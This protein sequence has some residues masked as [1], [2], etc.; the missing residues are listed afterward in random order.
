MQLYDKNRKLTFQVNV[1]KAM[2]SGGEG[3]ICEHPVNKSLVVKVYH[4]DRDLKLEQALLELSVLGPEFVKPEDICYTLNGRIAG[5]TMRFVDLNKYVILKKL[6]NKNTAA[7]L[8]FDK[9]VKYRIYQNLKAA[10]ESAHSKG[11]YIG[12]LNPYNIMVNTQ[13]EVVMLDVDSFGT[14][15][16]PHN[17][18]LLE[19][20]RDWLYHPKVSD[21]TDKF[22]FDV[23]TY[24]MFTNVHPFRGDYPKHITLEQRVV[25]KSSLVSG[26]PI[27]TP[28]GYEPF[29][30]QVI[31][32]Q[33]KEVF[34]DGKR[35]MVDLSGQPQILVTP[36]VNIDTV[37]S[38]SLNIRKITS[39]VVWVS[40]SKD[41]LAVQ[42]TSGVWQVYSTGF[43]GVYTFLHDINTATHVFCGDRGVAWL[44]NNYLCTTEGRLLDLPNLWGHTISDGSGTVFA[45]SDD[46]RYLCVDLNKVMNNRALSTQDVIYSKSVVKGTQ[47]VYQR[48]GDNK[49]LLDFKGH[50]FNLVKTGLNIKDVFK[51]GDIVLIEHVDNNKTRYTFCKING[52]KLEV[53]ADIPEFRWFDVKQGFVFVPEDQKINL[54]NPANNW[55]TVSEIECPVSTIDSG[56]FHTN[57]GMVIHTGS[58]VFL[59]NK[60]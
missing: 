13:G 1:A 23:L 15:S 21:E 17:G 42:K 39:D 35:F 38:N 29:T 32:S 43:Q 58:D 25:G 11:I 45:L 24:W 8:G 27:N 34:Q 4:Q 50:Q 52:L 51:R 9:K 28:K 44:E 59:V 3:S 37:A 55:Q 30:N 14:K 36:V 2:A 49:W 33:F 18:V 6:F 5:F 60:K 20:I 31:I 47:G 22:A 12:D 48:I 57:A 19:D 54:I 26:L 56:I 41:F 7:Q 53:C 16:K 40:A 46:D 10:V